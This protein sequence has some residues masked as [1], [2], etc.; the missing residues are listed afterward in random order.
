MA[1][2]GR[3]TY[4]ELLGWVTSD[5]CHMCHTFKMGMIWILGFSAMVIQSSGTAAVFRRSAAVNTKS[6]STEA[7]KC[8]TAYLLVQAKHPKRE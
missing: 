1:S 3:V 8:H 5:V 7:R 4:F 6:E 2:E